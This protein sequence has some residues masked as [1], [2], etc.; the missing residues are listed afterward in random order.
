MSMAHWFQT[1]VEVLL[2]VAIIFGFIYEPALARWE[3]KQKA[4]IIKAFEE[5]K[6]YRR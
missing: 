4:K 2:M 6:E 1:I 3:Q 5:R